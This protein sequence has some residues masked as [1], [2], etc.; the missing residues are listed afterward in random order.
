MK[1]IIYI[2]LPILLFGACSDVL[3]KYPLDE[4]TEASYWKKSADLE[5]YL[6]QY[7][8]D[9]KKL[10]SSWGLGVYGSEKNSDNLIG[11][12]PNDLLNGTRIV[13]D[14]KGGW[15]WSKIRSINYF[16][17]NAPNATDGL[18]S[19]LNHFKGEGYFFRAWYYFGLVKQFGDVPWYDKVLGTE[20]EELYAKRDARN[21]V[22]DNIIKDLDEA[23]RLMKNQDDVDL[24]RVHKGIALLFK[25]RVC[26]YEGTWEKYHAG[27][28]FGVVGSDGTKYLQ[29]AESAAWELMETGVYALYDNNKPT[30]DYYKLFNRTNHVST[31]EVLMWQNCSVDL[32]LGHGA[33]QYL[34]GD[35]AGGAGITKEL[36]DAYLCDNGLPIALAGD[37]YKGDVTIGDVVT[38]RDARLA[39]TTWVPG[40]TR[41][42]D[43]IFE[44]PNIEATSASECTTGY[45]IRKGST[46]DPNQQGSEIDQG[47]TAGIVFRYAEVL[48]NYAEARAELGSLTQDDL[49]KTI[50][51]LRDRAGV[52]PL[53]LNVGYVDPNWKFPTLSPIINEIRRE[54][55]VELALEGFRLGDIM[56][57]AAADELIVGVRP[58]GIK[59]IP[60][61][62][63]P[64]PNFGKNEPVDDNDY[65][66]Y[67]Q[68]LNADGYGFDVERDYLSPL[69]LD[70]LALNENLE[71]NPGWE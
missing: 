51:L 55:R 53:S 33:L 59:L 57:W 11:S 66:D 20:S 67:Y 5:L 14:D 68:T 65:L 1:K 28:E 23:I 49:D 52:S 64:D 24:G 63:F 10:P 39:Q 43:I 27:T 13:P 4:I 18:E 44:E 22:I 61:V 54:R 29:L 32:G 9:F 15:D 6:N 58:R 25:S 21:I 70:Q 36:V 31:K 16:I 42:D 34:N 2:I 48:L 30:E 69:P 60:G 40:Q 19:D 46:T 56:R 26:L 8:K 41:F 38:N 50:N 71:Q 35:K 12:Q 62:S 47:Q 3:D 37:Y 7:Y 45:Q 17:E